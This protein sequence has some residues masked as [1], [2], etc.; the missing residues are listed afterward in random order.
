M[1]VPVRFFRGQGS[2]QSPAARTFGAGWAS[3]SIIVYPIDRTRATPLDVFCPIDILRATLGV[4]PCQYILQTEGLSSE[5]N[6]TPDN[7]MTWVE[8]QFSKKQKKEADEVRRQLDAMVGHTRQ[9]DARLDQYAGL[10]HSVKQSAAATSNDFVFQELR[11]TLEYL[12]N[13]ID[14]GY[15]SRSAVS[16]GP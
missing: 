6:P 11:D 13:C 1:S 10:A 12:E 9:A 8:K 14:A 3:R 16:R 2:N 4:G 7:V 15:R 5:N